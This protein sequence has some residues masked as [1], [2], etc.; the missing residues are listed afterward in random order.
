MQTLTQVLLLL[1]DTVTDF[2]SMILLL[3]F[4]MQLMRVPFA[5]QI[6]AFVLQLTNWLVLPLRRVI[7]GVFG[8]DAASLL[9][10]YLLQVA[11]LSVRV[12]LHASADVSADHAVL[13]ILGHGVLTTLRLCV[14]LFIGLLLLQAVLSWTNPSSPLA[15]PIAQLTQPLL[16]PVQRVLPP[17]A[18]VDLSPFVLILIAQMLL[19][20]LR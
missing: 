1:I 15:R 7:P 5:N 20:V 2:F 4:F 13:W 12:A 17:I 11:V 10:A 3:R 8:V 9:P 6:G 16:R 14:Y 19:A 18:N